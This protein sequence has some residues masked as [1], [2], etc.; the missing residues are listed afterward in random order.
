[1]NKKIVLSFSTVFI[2]CG[3]IAQN[4]G[5]GT[6]TPAYKFDVIGNTRFTGHHIQTSAHPGGTWNY[7]INTSGTPTG[8]KIIT[9]GTLNGTNAGSF[10]LYND[11]NEPHFLV[12][13][14][15]NIG[16]GTM[17]PISRLHV[18]STGI[19]PAT[20]ESPVNEGTWV[21]LTNTSPGGSV[22]SLVS[23]GQAYGAGAGDLLFSASGYGIVATMR[24]NGNMGIGI[25]APTQ[26]LSINGNIEVQGGRFYYLDR[27]FAI[28]HFANSNGEPNGVC[29]LPYANNTGALGA[30]GSWWGN[31][32]IS[33][34]YY[35]QL[36][37]ISDQRTKRNIRP[38]EPVLDKIQRLQP[39][40]Y[41]INPVTH[42]SYKNAGPEELEQAKGTMGFTAQNIREVFPSMVVYNE[43]MGVY[44]IRN[45]DQLLS[46]LVQGMKEQQ[47]IIS[48]LETRVRILENR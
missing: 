10:M 7:L 3:I 31:G 20:F 39:I 14:S 15:G 29:I 45:Y 35:N 24:K 37:F 43:E 42:P 21:E 34:I 11:Q 41:D 5:I 8:W 38:L 30:P 40:R 23:T 44:T 6:S 48:K 27:Y 46:V 1:M 9:G 17:E 25:S 4:V 47:S 16:I 33:S 28:N 13:Q 22:W 18:V 12:R 32:Y 36:F 2:T 26:K 19:R